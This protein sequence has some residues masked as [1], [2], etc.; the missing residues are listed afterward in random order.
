L[1]VLVTSRKKNSDM[2]SP[3]IE[4]I[5]LFDGN[6]KSRESWYIKKHSNRILISALI[7]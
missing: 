6:N 5:L 1:F 7:S 3:S 4:I 2:K